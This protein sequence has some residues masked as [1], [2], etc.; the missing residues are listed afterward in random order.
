[1]GLSH[2]VSEIIGIFGRKLQI[3]RSV[4]LLSLLA[5]IWASDLNGHLIK[6]IRTGEGRI[7]PRE[8]R[9]EEGSIPKGKESEAISAILCESKVW[10][11]YHLSTEAVPRSELPM[12]SDRYNERHAEGNAAWMS[13]DA[14]LPLVDYSSLEPTVLYIKQMD[15]GCIATRTINQVACI[16]L[17]RPERVVYC[18]WSGGYFFQGKEFPPTEWIYK[19]ISHDQACDLVNI[20]A[21]HDFHSRRF[22]DGNLDI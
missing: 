4:G 1:M 3:P 6:A 16:F 21:Q 18:A 9:G 5:G 19:T 11:K 17:S 2:T 15:V 20:C 7:G 8:K 12:L 22:V 14:R 10:Q 13:Q